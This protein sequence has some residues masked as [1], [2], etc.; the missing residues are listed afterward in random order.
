[1]GA[2]LPPKEG[3]MQLSAISLQPQ[4]N[5]ENPFQNYF[6]SVFAIEMEFSKKHR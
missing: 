1:M 3:I 5:T 2:N 6:M 4:L